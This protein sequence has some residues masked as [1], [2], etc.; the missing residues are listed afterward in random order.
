MA[1][2]FKDGGN[3]EYHRISVGQGG[4]AFPIDFTFNRLY[5]KLFFKLE[6]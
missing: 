5:M 3:L 4:P 1:A 6:Y 2:I